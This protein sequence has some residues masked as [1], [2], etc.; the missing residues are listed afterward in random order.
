MP[1]L[2]PI[3]SVFLSALLLT[4]ADLGFGADAPV[5]RCPGP[6][7]VYTD[8]ISLEEASQRGCSTIDGSRVVVP[9]RPAPRPQ[10]APQPITP[11]AQ[12]SSA[13]T[14]TAFLVSGDG[15]LITNSHV[16]EG[17]QAGHRKSAWNAL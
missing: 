4:T 17:C 16:V 7:I 9:P 15:I 10:P 5:Y 11:R 2:T 14:G 3:L 13:K 12:E 6:P 1:R 8:K